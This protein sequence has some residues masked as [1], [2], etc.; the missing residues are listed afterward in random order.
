[1]KLQPAKF[2]HYI[3]LSKHRPI[4]EKGCTASSYWVKQA[5]QRLKLH[6]DHLESTLDDIAYTVEHAETFEQKRRALLML[7]ISG[8]LTREHVVKL[9][10][11]IPDKVQQTIQMP[12][13]MSW[14]SFTIL[15][16]TLLDIDGVSV[17]F[18]HI[19]RGSSS[20]QKQDSWSTLSGFSST[21]GLS[22]I[23]VVIFFSPQIIYLV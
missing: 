22:K 6:Y 21:F 23:S 4:K 7:N 16:D 10:G 12:R 11:I 19:Q 18:I 17:P 1:L 9:N 5:S 3:S 13:Q 14:Y 15:K 2:R 8:I 20:S